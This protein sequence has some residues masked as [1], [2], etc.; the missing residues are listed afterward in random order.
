M[1]AIARCRISFAFDVCSLSRVYDETAR[2]DILAC[3]GIARLLFLSLPLSLSPLSFNLLAHAVAASTSDVAIVVVVVVV[4]IVVGG[5]G[6][7]GSLCS[8]YVF[9]SIHDS[10]AALRIT[11]SDSTRFN[12][13]EKKA[14]SRVEI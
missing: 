6:N 4:V 5:G 3:V 7:G 12:Q 9:V 10:V 13:R 8:I 1:N 14:Y 2:T 11:A